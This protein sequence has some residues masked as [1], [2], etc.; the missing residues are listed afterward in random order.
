MKTQD[1]KEIR[2]TNK[3]LRFDFQYSHIAKENKSSIYICERRG[4]R[5][6]S[7]TMLQLPVFGHH[8][9][10]CTRKKYVQTVERLVDWGLTSHQQLR[11]YGDGTSVYS[12]IRRTG[13]PATPGL[14]GEWHNHYTTKAYQTVEKTNTAVMIATLRKQ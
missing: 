2:N 8:E 12:P 4:I 5:T 9:S 6:K 1:V 3:D 14:Q 11:S 10:R 13:E 7:S